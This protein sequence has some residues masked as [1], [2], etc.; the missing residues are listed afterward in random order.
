M[1]EVVACVECS[2]GPQAVCLGS[3]VG[4]AR[5]GRSD[6]RSLVLYRGVF[7]TVQR[8]EGTLPSAHKSE[9]RGHTAT[10]CSLI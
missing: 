2:L 9:H 6:L 8:G 3:G 4:D 5:P 1:P 10:T 7:S